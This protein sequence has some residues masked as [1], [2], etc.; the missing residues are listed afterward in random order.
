[1]HRPSAA[2]IRLS[3]GRARTEQSADR[4]APGLDRNIPETGTS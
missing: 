2:T 4:N 3:A 1:M